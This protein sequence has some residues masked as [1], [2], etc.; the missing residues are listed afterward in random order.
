MGYGV[1]A[2]EA[3]GDGVVN[4]TSQMQV[5]L[6]CSGYTVTCDGNRWAVPYPV[7]HWRFLNGRLLMIYDYKCGPKDALFQNLE[8]FETSGEKLWTAENPGTHS[9]DV[10]VDFISD[11]PLVIW[12]FSCICCT[13]D[14]QNGKLIKTVFSK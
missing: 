9:T 4:G 1:G 13:I 7:R 3:G 14:P 10:Y 11:E 12:S 2:G 8:A 6:S 5:G